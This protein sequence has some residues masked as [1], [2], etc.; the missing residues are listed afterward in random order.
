MRLG[1]PIFEKCSNA[2]EWVAAHKKL[3][4]SA[5]HCP[6]RADAPDETVREYADAA[7]AA[8][9][10]IAE[11]GAWSNP[12]SPDEKACR[13]AIA[14]CKRQLDLAER[15]GASCCVNIA[16]GC[17]AQW[18]GPDPGNYA[19][20]TFELIVDTVREIID[21]IKPTR[22]FYSL[23]PMPWVPPD[24]ADNYLELIKAVDRPR[25]AVHLDPVNMIT[26]PRLYY[27]NADM[28]RECFAKLGPYIKS[29]HG[30]DVTM[31]NEFNGHISQCQPGKG[32][33]D[34]AVFVKEMERLDPELPLFTEH[35]QTAR[36]YDQ[37]AAYIRKV[38]E[39]SGVNIL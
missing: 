19:D 1:G 23:E 13:E 5:A 7:K 10:V 32:T 9:I 24:S 3:G 38:A 2:R 35:L 20:E 18:D 34:Y 22:T 27:R 28:L 6:L 25:F 8:N 15:I 14:S 36:E 37:A 17:G 39:E 11:V 16:G 29:V 21:A 12:I 33:L 31:T 30:K 4:Y 26:S